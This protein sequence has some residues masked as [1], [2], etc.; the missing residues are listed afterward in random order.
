MKINHCPGDLAGA[1][2]SFQPVESSRGLGQVIFSGT[3]E[4]GMGDDSGV[5]G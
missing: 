5:V 2:V 3:R 1:P 4:H